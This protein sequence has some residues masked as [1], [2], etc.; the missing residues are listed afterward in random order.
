MFQIIGTVALLLSLQRLLVGHPFLEG[1]LLP[2]PLD[3]F[4]V[5]GSVDALF[6]QY[7]LTLTQIACVVGLIP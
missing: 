4:F 1:P 7:L 2:S 5:D 6:L 3:L